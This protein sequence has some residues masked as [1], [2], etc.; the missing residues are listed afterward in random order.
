MVI[1]STCSTLPNNFEKDRVFAKSGSY[2][3]VIQAEGDVA[4]ENPMPIQA[5]INEPNTTFTYTKYN[6]LQSLAQESLP[7][8][9]SQSN[10]LHEPTFRMPLNDPITGESITKIDTKLVHADG[11]LTLNF[12]SAANRKTYLD[13]PVNHP[14]LRLPY[15]ASTED[16]RGG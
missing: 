13:M 10:R 5:N 16:D 1:I 6:F 11:N 4:Q 2:R 12:T 15:P 7:R 9:K 3:V 8:D 14:N